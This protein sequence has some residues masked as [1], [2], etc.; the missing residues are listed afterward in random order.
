[1]RLL[2]L[3]LVLIL[4][5]GLIGAGAS[6]VQTPT[7]LPAGHQ[8]HRTPVVFTARLASVGDIMM[9]NTQITSGYVPGTGRYDFDHFFA[10]IHS[11]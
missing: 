10:D 9:H 5:V 2:K 3:L 11:L 4:T 7:D 1:M 8:E 6:V